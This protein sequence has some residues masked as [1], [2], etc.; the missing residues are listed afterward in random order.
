VVSCLVRG[1]YEIVNYK[2]LNKLVVIL[3]RFVQGFFCGVVML[4][5]PK[6]DHRFTERQANT[7][8]IAVSN[9]Y[10]LQAR[11]PICNAYTKNLPHSPPTLYF[12]KYK[13]ME[14]SEVAIKDPAYLKWLLT[15]DVKNT[16]K[17]HIE[18]ALH[19]NNG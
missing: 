10:H 7:R 18:R 15:Q 19:E 8:K 1:G 11:C 17:R 5:C 2:A 9:G 4:T 14:L 16:L 6:C 12:G 13:N 3:L